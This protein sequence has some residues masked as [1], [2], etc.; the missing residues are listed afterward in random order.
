MKLN[1]RNFLA[2]SGAFL[3][4]P[5]MESLAGEKAVSLKGKNLVYTG[6]NFGCSPNWW[7]EGTENYH[8]KK[9]KTLKNHQQDLSILRNF[10]ASKA[11]NPHWGTT[12]LLT[13]HN[14]FGT[15]GKYFQNAISCDQIAAKE[16]GQDYRYPSLVL[17][18][19][20]SAGT[21]DGGWG[22]GHSVLS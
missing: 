5:Q 2:A 17:S 18:S 3:A 22:P 21:G 10:D 16:F 8:F 12:T 11:G 19:P 15:P 7:D 6:F 20:K 13:C 14:V 4:L 9:L 1:R